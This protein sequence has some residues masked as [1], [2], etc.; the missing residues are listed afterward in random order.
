MAENIMADEIQ[1][2]DLDELA[3][4]GRQCREIIA[5][6]RAILAIV[7]NVVKQKSALASAGQKLAKFSKAELEA[8]GLAKPDEPLEPNEGG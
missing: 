3:T 6:N 8:L 1:E 5:K 2:M 4:V 7:K